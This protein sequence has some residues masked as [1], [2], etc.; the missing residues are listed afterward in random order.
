M[1]FTMDFR[2][3]RT[4][5]FVSRSAEQTRS[6]RETRGAQLA[7][8]GS[9]ALRSSPDHFSPVSRSSGRSQGSSSFTGSDSSERGSGSDASLR[10]SSASAGEKTRVWR[11][12]ESRGKERSAPLC[13]RG[14]IR[15][16]YRVPAA[17]RRDESEAAEPLPSVTRNTQI[18]CYDAAISQETFSFEVYCLLHQTNALYCVFERPISLV[19]SG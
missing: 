13:G 15:N 1:N 4:F 18:T 14:F 9:S 11:Q 2:T 8:R 16:T 12:K 19:K 3:R 6:K 5:P 10:A 7:S 17:A